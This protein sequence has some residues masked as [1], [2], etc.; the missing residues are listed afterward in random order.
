[1][2]AVDCGECVARL[3]RD[4]DEFGALAGREEGRRHREIE[5]PRGGR[6]QDEVLDRLEPPLGS[7]E[8]REVAADAIGRVRERKPFG[9]ERPDRGASLGGREGGGVRFDRALRQRHPAREEL[10]DFPGL[11]VGGPGGAIARERV[12]GVAIG[13][14]LGRA[15]RAE[16]LGETRGGS[17]GVRLPRVL[18]IAH[19]IHGARTGR[20]PCGGRSLPGVHALPEFDEGHR[21]RRD[22]RARSRGASPADRPPRACSG[23]RCR[24]GEG[25]DRRERPSRVASRRTTVTGHPPHRAPPKATAR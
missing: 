14:E 7:R 20:R 17:H 25:Q 18:R 10:G 3:L 11:R 19:A 5:C 15:Q 12:D 13:R 2:I 8:P 6:A 23:C 9:G 21:C 24:R 16:P 4:C 22:G 1:M